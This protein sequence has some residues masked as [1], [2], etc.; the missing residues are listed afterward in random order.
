[1]SNCPLM[2]NNNKKNISRKYVS[3]LFGKYFYLYNLD[4]S[5]H[6]EI[7]SLRH[8]CLKLYECCTQG[9]LINEVL[10]RG[11]SF[12]QSLSQFTWVPYAGAITM[13]TSVVIFILK[14]FSVFGTKSLVNFV[15]LQPRLSDSSLHKAHFNSFILQSS[16]YA[17]LWEHRNT[18]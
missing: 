11:S 18:K 4:H 16:H 14:R 6:S 10:V 8:I 7:L 12:F 1:M 13:N 15:I 2:L 5:S 9:F 17:P 3:V